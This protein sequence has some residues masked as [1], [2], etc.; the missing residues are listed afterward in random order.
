MSLRSFF[1]KRASAL[2]LVGFLGLFAV[3][4]A[5]CSGCDGSSLMCDAEGN[6]QI[7]DAYG[8]HPADAQPSGAGGSGAGSS[9]GGNG[10]AGGSEPK[11]D[12]AMAACPCDDED[13]CTNGT[14]CVQGLCVDGCDF[15]YEC[16]AGNVCFN[17][18]CVPECDAQVTCDVGYKCDKGA[19]VLD[20]A[21]PQCSDAAPC[22]AGEICVGGLC[23][24]GCTSN[25]DCA[26]GEICN[27]GTGACVVDPSPQPSCS[28]A[29]T[30]PAPQQCLPDGY[31]HYPCASLNDCKA[32]DNHF[33]ACESVC[34]T[35]EEIDPECSLDVPCKDGKDCVSNKCL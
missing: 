17:G 1:T 23:T 28:G 27:A 6:C 7:C 2:G 3:S 12:P 9:V 14:Q 30:C 26:E 22:E 15:T 29:V 18:A 19:C 11:C 8:C 13:A 34:K 35:Q 33:V 4:A 21:N 24:T 5:G 25:A 20:P 10:G 16:G 32:I 31:C